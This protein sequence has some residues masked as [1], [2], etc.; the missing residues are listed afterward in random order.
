MNPLHHRSA[1]A[2][3][4]F[5]HF[6]LLGNEM[7]YVLLMP[8]LAWLVLDGGGIVRQF[9]F[10]AF[11]ACFLTNAVKEILRLPRPPQRLHV[12]ADE[13]VTQQYGFPSTHSAHALTLSWLLG[14]EAIRAHLVSPSAGWALA[15]LNTAHVCLSRLYMGVH[16]LA[17]VVGGLA[18]GGLILAVFSIA[19]SVVFQL[20]TTAN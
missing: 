9:S 13:H 15:A 5:S 3:T 7:Q 20:C 14:R 11:I 6:P 10:V 17:D 12:R 18:V 1:A 8:S 16:S 19:G 4:W 2:D